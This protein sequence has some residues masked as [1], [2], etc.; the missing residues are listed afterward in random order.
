MDQTFADNLRSA[1]TLLSDGDLTRAQEY[2]ELAARQAEYGVSL[3]EYLDCLFGLS[4]VYSQSGAFDQ[5]EGTVKLALSTIQKQVGKEHFLYGTHLNHMAVVRLH[6]GRLKEAE[7]V[8]LESIQ[9]IEKYYNSTHSELLKPL[10]N[11]GHI[12][13]EQ[14][15]ISKAVQSWE[16]AISIREKNFGDADPGIRFFRSVCRDALASSRKNQKV[17]QQPANDSGVQLRLFS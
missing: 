14:K 10:E 3:Q 7:A 13:Q 9:I 12:Y 2:F 1:Q 6:Q 8:L 4:T 16:R 17:M 5:A 11:L 15:Q